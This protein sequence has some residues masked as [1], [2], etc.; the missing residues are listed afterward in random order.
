MAF[1]GD[2]YLLETDAAL[3]L[4]DHIA[5]RPIIDPHNHIDLEEI[6]DNDT[7][8][9]IW[10]VEGATDHYVWQLMRKRGVPEAKI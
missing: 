9:D 1:L 5:D 8:D 4:Y 6:L 3:T 2:D 10:E 7:W